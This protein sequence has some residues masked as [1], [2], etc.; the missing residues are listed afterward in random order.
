MRSGLNPVEC[1]KKLEGRLISF[2]FKD[3]NKAGGDAH[4]VPWGTGACNVPAMLA[5]CIGR[6]SRRPSSSNTNITGR[7]RCRKSPS[8]SPISTRCRPNWRPRVKARAG[9]DSRGPAAR[10]MRHKLSLN[11]RVPRLACPTVPSAPPDKPAVAP[12][13]PAANSSVTLV[14]RRNKSVWFSR[15]ACTPWAIGN[16][17]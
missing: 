7:L 10:E 9:W 11:C 14:V 17:P 8:Q 3:L 6:E 1:L 13:P 12:K 16:W 15:R 2:H 4:D 5:E